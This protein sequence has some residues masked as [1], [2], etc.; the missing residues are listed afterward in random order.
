MMNM[1]VFEYNSAREE[2]IMPEY[3]RHIQKMVQHVK[4]IE[5]A[6][7]RQEYAAAIVSLM[8]Q[9]NPQNKTMEDY[10]TKMWQ[11]LFHI[12]EYDIVLDTPDGS[13][14]QPPSQAKVDHMDY[15][16]SASYKHYGTLLLTMVDKACEM[17]PGD[18]KDGFINIIGSFM[19]MAHRTWSKDNYVEDEMIRK[20]IKKV[21]KGRLEAGPEAKFDFYN[22]VRIKTKR[23]HHSNNRNNRHRNHKNRRKRN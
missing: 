13:I 16:S 9:M 2:L 23:S 1:D 22:G 18:K 15:P 7:K 19:K 3:G 5:D 8:I 17:E 10:H 14:P 21:S 6:E 12:A 11:H 4:T 20:E